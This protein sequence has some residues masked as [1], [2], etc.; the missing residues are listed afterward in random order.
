MT[1]RLEQKIGLVTG[2]ASG[3]GAAAAKLFA[4]EG[5]RVVIADL[6]EP[7][8]AELLDEIA[9]R[10]DHFLHVRCDVTSEHDVKAAVNAALEKWGRLDAVVASAGIPGAGSDTDM[11]ED[12]WDHVMAINVKGVFFTTK[13]AIPALVAGGGG[14]ITNISSVYG[15]RGIPGFVAY[16]TAKGGVQQMTKS[17]AIAHAAEGVRTNCI[18]PG[19]IEGPLLQKIID[20]SDDPQA[21]RARYSAE[22]PNGW[23]GSPDDIG[24]GCVYLASDEARFVNGVALPIDGGMLA[25]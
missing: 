9:Q 20:A 16:C 7:V 8:D 13:H 10:P 2:G 5:A 23:N 1:G 3:I 22:Q 14:S 6:Q 11:T 21:T 24:W 17:T 25:R 12:Q 15:A 4:R 19:T 18:L